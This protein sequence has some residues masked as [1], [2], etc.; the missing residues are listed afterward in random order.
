M[1][2]LPKLVEQTLRQYDLL[3]PGDTVLVALSGGPDSTALLHILANMRQ[4]WQLSLYA[5]HLNHGIR[6]EEADLDA[7]HAAA[8]CRALNVPLA[9]ERINVPAL[10]KNRR[11]SMQEAAREARHAFLRREAQRASARRIAVGHTRDDRVETILLN[12]MRGCGPEGLEGFPP[13]APPLIRPLY[14]AEKKDTLHYC[15]LHQLNAR[16]DSSNADMHYS[17]NRVRTEL[18]PQMRAYYNNRVDDALLRMAD[19]LAEENAYMHAQT[20]DFLAAHMH[21]SDKELVIDCSA[22]QALPPALQKRAVRGMVEAGKGN[23]QGLTFQLV[24]QV[25]NSCRLGERKGWQIAQTSGKWSLICDGDVLRMHH[26]H[27]ESAEPE[28]W[29][30]PLEPGRPLLLHNGISIELRI[31]SD[32]QSLHLLHTE[33]EECT[34]ALALP[35]CEA[36]LPLQVRSRLPGDRMHLAGGTKLLQDLLVDRKVKRE[37]RSQ[38]PLIADAKGQILAAAGVA[39]SVLAA[40]RSRWHSLAEPGPYLVILVFVKPV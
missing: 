38:T 1:N 14:L 17:R 29:S 31:L 27:T 2:S 34:E 21:R 28:P 12:L 3:Q 26:A 8:L 20:A 19:I 5:A 30:H 6:G 39:H 25:L 22:L 24:E 36:S 16:I 32:M 40:N 37:T 10:R 18:L 9:S 4:Q 11:L 7:E 13:A 33:A 15:L 23:I 35:A